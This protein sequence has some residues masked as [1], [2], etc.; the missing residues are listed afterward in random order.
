MR[1]N[2]TDRYDIISLVA[3]SS[4]LPQLYVQAAILDIVVDQSSLRCE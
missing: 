3:T 2:H 4:S 1:Y